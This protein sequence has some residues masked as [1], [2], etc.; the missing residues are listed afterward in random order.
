MYRQKKNIKSERETLVSFKLP[1]EP[2]RQGSCGCWYYKKKLSVA[3][4]ISKA[5]SSD[6]VPKPSVPFGK[7][8]SAL[9][10][11]R[12]GCALSSSSRANRD[13]TTHK[14]TFFFVSV[15]FF[16]AL[17]YFR[18]KNSQAFKCFTVERP[19]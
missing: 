16:K 8:I 4:V 9:T 15:S 1:Q 18:I 3:A 13:E 2:H 7:T 14:S 10:Q 17:C 11:S 19:N 12:N 5:L 6:Q